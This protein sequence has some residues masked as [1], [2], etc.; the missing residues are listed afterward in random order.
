MARVDWSARDTLANA[1]AGVSPL[2]AT[3]PFA[4]DTK[5]PHSAIQKKYGLFTAEKRGDYYDALHNKRNTV[6]LFMVSLFG[7]LSAHALRYMF[8]LRKRAKQ[9]RHDTTD[10]VLGGPRQWMAH[11][12]QRL[13][14]AVVM[15]DAERAL[16]RAA[17]LRQQAAA[18]A[19]PHGPATAAR[20]AA[21]G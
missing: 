17:D 9:R 14:A 10:Y 6:F 19:R 15:G 11:W 7:G 1:A 8:T 4:A 13:S 5:K 2:L 18:A 20:P 12:T 21:H 16:A 3:E